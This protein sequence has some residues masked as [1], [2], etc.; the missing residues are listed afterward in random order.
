LALT[1][2]RNPQKSEEITQDVF[3]HL[4]EKRDELKAVKKFGVWLHVIAR[5]MVISSTR[6][7]LRALAGG[8]QEFNN[9][10]AAMETLLVPDRQVEYKE[11]YQLLLKGIELL[12]KQ[13]RQVFKMS[14]LEGLS[15]IEIAEKLQ[16]HPVT[17][18]QYMAKAIVFLKA[19][20]HDHTGDLILAIVLMG[21]A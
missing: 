9:E 2:T 1:Y 13:R 21:G 15:N 16:M 6:E 5:N 14:R 10:D 8:Y 18:S 3:L 7:K 20:L 17:V 11:S 4:W 12:P 19:Y